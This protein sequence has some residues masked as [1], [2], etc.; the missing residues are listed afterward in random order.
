MLRN[1]LKLFIPPIFIWVY[2]KLRGTSRNKSASNYFWEGVYNDFNE[3]M[4]MPIYIQTEPDPKCYQ[5]ALNEKGECTL[6]KYH[7]DEY[8]LR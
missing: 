3:I 4:L 2:R 7:W 8:P 5:A 6:I 1:T